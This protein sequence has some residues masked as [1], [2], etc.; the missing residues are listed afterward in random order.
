[1]LPFFLLGCGDPPV[2]PAEDGADADVRSDPDAGAERD[3]QADTS[4]ASSSHEDAGVED[5]LAMCDAFADVL[6][7]PLRS[8]CN[9][10]DA[11]ID[12]RVAALGNWCREKV[13]IEWTTIDPQRFAECVESHRAAY[14][15]CLMPELTFYGNPCIEMNLGLLPEGESCFLDLEC[16]AGLVC[17]PLVNDGVD[18][19]GLCVTPPSEGQACAGSRCA[20]GLFCDLDL[21]TREGTCLSRR[22]L[23]DPCDDVD[24]RLLPCVEGLA[25]RDGRCGALGEAGEPC[26]GLV[27][28]CAQGLSC[29]FE[30][31][32]CEPVSAYS[33]PCDEDARCDG[34]CCSDQ[35]ACGRSICDPLGC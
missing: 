14:D 15:L 35:G 21:E 24:P 12:R 33:E 22:E 28:D 23:D 7:E 34:G 26:S 10:D 4:D 17:A 11:E 29:A 27:P 1:M 2:D 6:Q 16:S 8:C 13:A 20:E 3:G 31:G 5:D 30:A 32:T 25:C 18:V 9:V 19:T